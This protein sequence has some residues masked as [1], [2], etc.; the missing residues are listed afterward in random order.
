MN[1][2]GLDALDYA[3]SISGFFILLFFIVLFVFP[4][5][6]WCNCQSKII[7]FVVAD[8]CFK[9][10]TNVVLG[11]FDVIDLELMLR[12]DALDIVAELDHNS[13]VVDIA[14]KTAVFGIFLDFILAVEEVLG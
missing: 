11:D 13:V 4:E 6:R 3:G 8:I 5:L 1:A 9:G 7:L 14:D 10:L 12:Y 2:V